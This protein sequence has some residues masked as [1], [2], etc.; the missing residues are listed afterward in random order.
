[1]ISCLEV[2]TAGDPD[3]DDL[4]FTDLSPRQL[5][6]RLEELGTPVGRDAIATWLDE[7]GFRRRQIRKDLA[8]GEHPDRDAQ[9]CRIAELIEHYESAGNPWFSMDTKAKEHLGQLHRKGR[10]RSSAPFQ[11]FDHDFPSWADGVL[12]PHGIFDRRANLGHLNLGLSRDTT[13]FACDSFR[14]FWNRIGKRRYP[15]ATSILLTCDGG[16]SNSARKHIFK[17]DLQRLSESIGIEIRVAHY[18]P[19][20]SKYNPIEHR[21]FP[22]LTRACQG[23][24]CSSVDLVKDLMAKTTTKTGLEVSVSMLDK[25]YATGRKVAATCKEHMRVIFDD[26]RPQWHYRI[27]P[28]H[29]PIG[30]V[31]EFLLLMAHVAALPSQCPPHLAAWALP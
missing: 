11:E 19:Y 22:H 5:A 25:V 18:P 31:I 27:I 30:E 8:G 29:T 1:L 17:W 4:F 15:Q 10:V 26:E 12:I 7:A 28:G 9:F 2:R 14:W 16:G 6:E 24:I 21:L 23:V 20:C 3:R 13:E